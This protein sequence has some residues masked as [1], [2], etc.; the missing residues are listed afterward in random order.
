MRKGFDIIELAFVII[1]LGILAGA[2][3]PKVATSHATGTILES[4]VEVGTEIREE[5]DKKSGRITTDKAFKAHLKAIEDG[6]DPDV[7]SMDDLDG[8]AEEPV[9]VETP[10]EET[11][12]W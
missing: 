1:I 12:G 3:V 9:E 8:F 5:L 7:A 6:T 4:V 11:Y 10:K 2:L